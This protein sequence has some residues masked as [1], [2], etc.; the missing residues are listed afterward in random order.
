MSPAL[1]GRP[2]TTEPP[3]APKL[4]DFCV[5]THTLTHIHLHVHTHKLLLTHSHSCP[6]S[7]IHIFTFTPSHALT[8]IHSPKPSYSHSSH[9]PT[10]TVVCW[11]QPEP[12]HK[13]L[14]LNFQ[15]FCEPVTQRSH[16]K[17][18][19]KHII[20]QI[21]LQIKLTNT[22]NSSLPNYFCYT[23]L[24]SVFMEL[25]MSVVSEIPYNGTSSLGTQLIKK[26]PEMQETQVQSLGWKDPLKKRMATHFST[27]AWKTPWTEEPGKLQ[28]M[29]SQRVGHN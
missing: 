5:Y 20:K 29:R 4:I 3:E 10:H 12:S 28:S 6:R 2:F 1:T 13:R 19:N 26:M 25:L 15:E 17:S 24:L 22:Q 8:Q 16:Y 9:T 18:N 11:N 23:L 27:L 14:L 21:T 7:H